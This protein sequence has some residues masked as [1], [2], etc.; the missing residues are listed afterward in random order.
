MATESAGRYS[1]ARWAAE[2]M[3]GAMLSCARKPRTAYQS[4]SN[5]KN[6]FSRQIRLCQKSCKVCCDNGQV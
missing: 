2:M 5:G 4:R 3:E 6:V 1:C